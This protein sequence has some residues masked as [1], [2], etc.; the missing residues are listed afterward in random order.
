MSDQVHY[1]L[2]VR[3]KPG[4]QWTLD[5]ATEIRTHALQTAEEAL[6]QG[7]AIA[8]R[9]SKKPSTP[10]PA[11]T[12]RS[13]SSPRVRSDGGKPGRCRRILIPL[14]PAVR[15]LHRPRARPHR[16]PAG[17][18]PGPPPRH[19][20]R[21]AAPSRPG[22]EAGSLRHRPAAR[23]AEDRHPRGRG[24][25]M[26]V[27]ELIRTFQGLVERTVA[28]LDEGVQEG[29]PARPGQGRLRP[30]RRAAVHRSRPRLPC[31]GPASPPR[32]RPA[33]TGPRSWPACWTWP[34]PRPPTPR[35][36]PL[37]WPPSK[38][39]W[40]R[41]SAPRPAWPTCWGPARPTS[42]PPWPP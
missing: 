11:N 42:A 12:S 8:V 3:R 37:P 39:R 26:S 22:R 30:R 6:E 33:R 17:R 31:W 28:N 29:R 4:A 1:E 2:F 23:S 38:R 36:A 5:M 34:T 32:S 40:P 35:P 13:R 16:P 20:V 19:A 9:V 24:R 18:L 7:R 15:P 10:R 27:H 21:A 25:G 41:S 14:R